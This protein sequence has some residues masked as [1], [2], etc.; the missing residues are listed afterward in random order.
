MKSARFSLGFT[1]VELLIVIA[2]LG[3]LA[4]AVLA[5]INP[6]EQANRARDTRLKSDSSQLLAA[7]D[8]Y[9]A[10]QSEMPWAT[11]TDP[12]PAL[13]WVDAADV[14]V[15]I[16]GDAAC[17]TDGVLLTNLELKSEFRNRDFLK[18]AT[19]A[20][21]RVKVGKGAA[22]S[23][24]VY[25]CFVPLSTSERQKTENLRSLGAVGGTP[26]SGC[27]TT[28]WTGSPCYICIPQ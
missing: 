8:R 22:A 2:L 12:A 25:S 5:A 3:I 13:D 23:A 6:I 17:S 9:F 24:S 4:A 19:P 16:C 21:N 11:P 18:S 14:L 26:A 20:L 10:S 7:I 28:D 1:L 27:T 15:G